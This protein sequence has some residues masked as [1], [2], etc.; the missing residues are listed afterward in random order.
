MPAHRP[1]RRRR[2]RRHRRPHG[3]PRLAR[4]AATCSSWRARPTSAESCAGIGGGRRGRRGCRGDARPSS[5]GRRAGARARAA[6]RAP[7]H[8]LVVDLDPGRAAATAALGDGRPQQR[9]TGGG[10]RRA[11]RRGPRATAPRDP[12]CPQLADG[13]DVSVGELVATRLGDEVVDRLVEPLLGGVYAGHSRLLS[14]RATVPQLPPER[15][16]FTGCARRGDR[17]RC[18]G[19]PVFAGVAGGLGRL[20]V[21]WRSGARGPHRRDRARAEAHRDRLRARGRA[22]HGSRAG[23]ADE[24]VLAV[25]PRL[26]PGCSPASRPRPPRSSRRSSLRRW[27]S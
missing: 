3:C 11:Q 18:D 24:V 15:R 12:R 9:R 7:R 26:P 13:E 27:P 22:D 8:Q 10:V 14:A 16:R 17:R 21:P 1:T 25:R 2:G 19:R 20:P 23:A 6:D 5:R 4:P